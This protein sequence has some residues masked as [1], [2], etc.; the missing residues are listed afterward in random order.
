MTFKIHCGWN[1]LLGA[2]FKKKR[3]LACLTAESLFGSV[4]FLEW[5]WCLKNV[6]VWRTTMIE[7]KMELEQ[8]KK[9]RGIIG[10]FG[11]VFVLK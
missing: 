3:L 5:W 9:G 8:K 2:F 10:F 11:Y 7:E 6:H 1:E 4:F